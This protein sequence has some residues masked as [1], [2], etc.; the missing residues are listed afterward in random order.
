MEWF[1][2]IFDRRQNGEFSRK[3]EGG[4]WARV[5]DGE[6]EKAGVEGVGDGVSFIS[7]TFTCLL[8]AQCLGEMTSLVSSKDGPVGYDTKEG[9]SFGT[10]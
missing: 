1:T 4:M 6:G 7:S 3:F 9:R 5:G 10:N 8:L 2:D